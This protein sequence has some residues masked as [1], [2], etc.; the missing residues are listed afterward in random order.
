LSELVARALAEDATSDDIT[1]RATVPEHAVGRARLIAR[2][3]CVVAGLDAF[4]E[5]MRRVDAALVVETTVGD[6][7]HVDAGH[8][9]ATVYGSLGAILSAER[10]AL[11]FIQRLSGV[12]TA[13]RAFVDAAGGVAVLDTRKTTPGMRLLE[14]AAVRAGGG[15]N[16]RMDLSAA[17]LIKD[18][19]IVAAGGVRPAVAA[20]RRLAGERPVQVECETLG[21]VGEAVAAGADSLL[22][23]N[24]DV[25]TLREAV[26]LVAG[27]ATLEASGGVTLDTIAEIA[28][29]GVD[30][31]S[32]GALTHS[33][34]AIDLSL[35]LEQD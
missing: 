7:D 31:I 25:A 19:H 34:P 1:T 2:E 18:N 35:E 32:V 17:V 23:D 12:A 4:A 27:R 3:P 15:M 29:S 9:V 30:A 22:L 11:N 24:M 8:T 10:T 26:T 14:K 16:H 33:A 6:G 20:A 21:E 28:T 13:T 5:T